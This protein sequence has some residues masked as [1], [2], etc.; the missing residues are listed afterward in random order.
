MHAP[1]GPTDPLVVAYALTYAARRR[2]SYRGFV[3]KADHVLVYNII[4][5]F[6]TLMSVR[7]TDP[8]GKNTVPSP[9]TIQI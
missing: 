2:A 9:T 4:V 6:K 7:Y 3:R 5:A 8:G 1:H